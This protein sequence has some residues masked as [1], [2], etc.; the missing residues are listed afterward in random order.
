MGASIDAER[1][2]ELLS[3]LPSKQQIDRRPKATRELSATIQILMKIYTCYARNT[4][5]EVLQLLRD[6]GVKTS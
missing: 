2:R 6:Y 5:V 4:D 3:C 1:H